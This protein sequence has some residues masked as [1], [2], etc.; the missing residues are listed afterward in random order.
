MYFAR[1]DTQPGIAE[2]IMSNWRFQQTDQ[3]RRVRKGA[4]EL[5]KTDLEKLSTDQVRR[6]ISWIMPNDPTVEQEVW[7]RIAAELHERWAAETDPAVKG[8]FAQSL[9]QVLSSRIGTDEYLAF[10]REQMEKASD[11]DRTRCAVQLFDAMLSQPW[12]MEHENE[13]FSLLDKLS[14]S[15][16]PAERWPLKLAHYI[17]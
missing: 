9:V 10:L 11:E 15:A 17:A 8:Q 14:D 12:S 5:L 3:C 16:E 7:K 6:Y 2:N 1:N 13:L 4:A